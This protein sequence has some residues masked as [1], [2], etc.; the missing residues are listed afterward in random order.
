MFQRFLHIADYKFGCSE[1]SSAGSYDPA[2]ECFMVA[3]GDLADDT[4]ALG[5][6]RGGVPCGATTARL[7]CWRSLRTR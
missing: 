7:H 5:K 6:A 1:D 3:I 2:R 4:R